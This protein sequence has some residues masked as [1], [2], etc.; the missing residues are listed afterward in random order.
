MSERRDVSG[1][2]LLDKAKGIT[3]NRALQQVK[4]LFRARKAGHT[5]SLDPLATGLLPLCLGEATKVCG[6]LLNADKGYHVVARLG[7]ATDTYDAEGEVIEDRGFGGVEPALLDRILSQ[8]TGEIEQIP[9][10]HSALKHQGKR[11]YD[12]ARKGQTVDRP[13][14]KVTIHDL[15][16][17]GLEGHHL[18]L[19]VKCTKGTYIRSLVS[20]IGQRIGCGAFVAALRRTEVDPFDAD[21]MVG[22]EA[23]EALAEEGESRLDSVLIAPDQALQH[24]PDVQLD[25]DSAFY[26]RQ[27]QAVTVGG[28]PTGGELRLYGPGEDFIGIGHVLDDGRVGPRRLFRPAQE[29]SAG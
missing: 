20:D 11:L 23:L 10:M 28:A 13:P 15:R 12:L 29:Q 9:P 19:E 22:F 6:Y 24:L 1:I 5:G 8:F 21:A 16:M 26:V 7:Q 25:S 18:E 14:R 4:R 27:G 17:L 2:V 3:S